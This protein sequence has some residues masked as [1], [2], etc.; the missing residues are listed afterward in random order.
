MK[1]IDRGMSIEAMKGGAWC[2]DGDEEK[3]GGGE[4][5]DGE[6]YEIESGRL[7]DFVASAPPLNA[8][9]PSRDALL[10][11]AID[12]DHADSADVRTADR[13]RERMAS[14]NKPNDAANVDAAV[15]GVQLTNQRLADPSL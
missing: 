6:E 10:R 14:R 9:I 7:L 5:D 2:R 11:I 8:V 3:D 13:R 12:C 15:V 1:M 4:V